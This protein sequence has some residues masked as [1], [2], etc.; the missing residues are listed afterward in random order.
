VELA[1]API[2]A[3]AEV[4]A[5][6]T[7]G[8]GQGAAAQDAHQVLVELQG[9]RLPLPSP[10]APRSLNLDNFSIRNELIVVRCAQV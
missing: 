7:V 4:A 10:L 5:V 9:A 1:A 2:G 6:P 8:V 3:Q